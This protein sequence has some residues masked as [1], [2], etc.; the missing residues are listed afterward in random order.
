MRRGLTI[1]ARKYAF[2]IG[3]FIIESVM[4][5]AR[6]LRK[7]ALILYYHKY[8]ELCLLYNYV[9]AHVRDFRSYEN[10]IAELATTYAFKRAAFVNSW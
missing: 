7:S 5:F 1:S 10:I 6:K 2:Y 4:I 8:G 9:H 3:L